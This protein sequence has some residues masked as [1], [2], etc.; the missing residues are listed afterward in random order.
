MRNR[1]AAVIDRD[2]VSTAQDGVYMYDR[3]KGGTIGKY[4]RFDHPHAVVGIRF[5]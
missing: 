3:S 4:V 1:S 5:L 2:E